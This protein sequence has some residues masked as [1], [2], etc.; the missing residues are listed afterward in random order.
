MGSGPYT[1]CPTLTS[2][3]LRSAPRDY[4]LLVRNTPKSIQPFWGRLARME[5]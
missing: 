3:P 4:R 1:G 2:Y 5:M